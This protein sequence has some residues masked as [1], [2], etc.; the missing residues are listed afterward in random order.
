MQVISVNLG[1][2]ETVRTGDREVET[3][4]HKRP[5][6]SA[7]AGRTGLAG[8]TIVS[9]EHHGGPDQAVYLYSTQD[10]A[11]WAKELGRDDLQPGLFG[12]NLTVDLDG[13]GPLRVGDRFTIG[14]VVLEVTAPRMPCAKFQAVV[15]EP[16]WRKTFDAARRHGAYT[17][18]LAEGTVEEGMAIEYLPADP[19]HPEIEELADIYLEPKADP[20]RLEAALAAPVA[21]RAREAIERRLERRS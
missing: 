3:G 2:K 13:V 6:A 17:R 16:D 5:V 20:A 9:E 12:E 15:A 21:E 1:S 18:V 19:S 7:H 10:Y 8:D 14:E 4:I 11:W